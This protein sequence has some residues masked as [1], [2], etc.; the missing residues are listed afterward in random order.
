MT[1]LQIIWYGREYSPAW[2]GLEKIITKTIG[3]KNGRC[4]KLSSTKTIRKESAE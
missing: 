4:R 2:V 3:R 1:S